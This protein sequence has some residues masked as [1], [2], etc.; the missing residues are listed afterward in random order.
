M[1]EV[2]V[3]KQIRSRTI[4]LIGA[5]GTN[6]GIVPTREAY[7][8]ALEQGLDLIEVNPNGRY[9]T[10]KL[11]DYGKWKYEQKKA[12]KAQPKHLPLK[13]VKLSAAI[14]S[15]DYFVRVERAIK[16]LKGGH[17]VK[18]TMEFKKGYQRRKEE[19]HILLRKFTKDLKDVGLWD[20]ETRK[21][22]K[23]VSLLFK[24][25]SSTKEVAEG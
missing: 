4:L 2:K 16:F 17:S 8:A 5:D 12:I 25:C 15:A 11:L 6:L 1:K 18:V 3:N 19:G 10:C 20:G 13:E 22:K 21:A 7:E 14:D 24:P 9:P 23:G